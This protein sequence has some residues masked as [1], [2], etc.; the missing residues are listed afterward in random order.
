MSN[1][2]SRIS[3]IPKEGREFAKIEVSCWDRFLVS[4]RGQQLRGTLWGHLQCFGARRLVGPPATGLLSPC[5]TAGPCKGHACH[6][7][8]F[9][10]FEQPHRIHSSAFATGLSVTIPSIGMAGIPITFGFIGTTSRK[11]SANR[12]FSCTSVQFGSEI[13]FEMTANPRLAKAQ[14]GVSPQRPKPES[15]R[16]GAKGA[17]GNSQERKW[18]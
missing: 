18:K 5:L 10:A 13:H 17:K 14:T 16:K 11:R 15:H 2:Y 9:P 4:N 3:G 7:R 1:A 12:Y 6:Q 8:K